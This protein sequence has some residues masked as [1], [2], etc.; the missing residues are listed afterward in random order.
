MRI[1]NLHNYEAYLLDFSEGNL[2]DECQM[3]L[4]LFLIQHPELDID[5][6]EL[7]M[8]TIEDEQIKF[9][10]KNNLKKSETDLVSETQFI[11]YIENQISAKER[12]DIEKSCAINPVLLKELALYNNTI[13]KA[14]ISVVYEK[15]SSLKRKPKVIWF[16][17]SATQFAAAACVVF[18]IGLFVLWPKTDINTNTLHLANNTGTPNSIIKPTFSAINP[19]KNNEVVNATKEP[20]SFLTQQLPK[21]INQQSFANTAI[22][23]Q[24]NNVTEIKD[25][26]NAIV[27]TNYPI[28]ESHKNEVFIAQNTPTVLKEN[29][30][31]IVEVITENDEEPIAL[32]TDKKKQ[33]IWTTVSRTLKNLNHVGVKSV[34]GDEENNKENTSY[35]LTLGGISITHKADNL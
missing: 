19:Q 5:L 14:D 13:V 30:Q 7:S 22:T 32:N 15:K 23:Q 29:R 8:V 10:D 21:K 6:A 17:F 26:L 28:L 31:T 9:L 24:K 20:N 35:A 18:L 34:N 16:N 27:N 1:I 25:T 2:S 3:E 11:G 33:G 4:E 12:L